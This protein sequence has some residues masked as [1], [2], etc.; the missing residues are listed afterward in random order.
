MVL[1]K[2]YTA[3][4]KTG[5]SVRLLAVVFGVMFA[6]HACGLLDEPTTEDVIDNII[7]DWKCAENSDNFGDQNYEVVISKATETA[8]NISNFF[9]SSITV[10]AEVVGYNL[11]IPSQSKGGYTIEGSGTISSGYSKISLSYSVTDES[12]TTNCTATYTVK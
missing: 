7:G 5:N 12:E 11:T 3:I 2:V 6:L 10:K 8:V 9:G 1:Y 4:K